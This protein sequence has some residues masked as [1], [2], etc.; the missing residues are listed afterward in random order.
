LLGVLVVAIS[1]VAF[2][3]SI[4]QAEV[5]WLVLK[6][7][8]GGLYSG[9]EIEANKEKFEASLENATVAL[10]S[11]VG[12]TK[13]A[14]TCT[15]TELVDALLNATGGLKEGAKAK[16]TG[17]KFFSG[18]TNG[19]QTEQTKC[20]PKTNGGPL[21]TVET[22]PFHALVKSHEL[23]SGEKDDTLLV[24]PD[25]AEE[26][27]ISLELGA[28]CAFGEELPTFGLLPPGL[29]RHHE[30]LRTPGSPLTRRI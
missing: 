29:R 21:G 7:P 1:L 12:I 30:S 27:V 25:N 16:F 18:G 26:R 14:I 13:I 28:S 9:A 10:L 3:A 11:E 22:L 8:T 4:A 20:Q 23:K 6:V 17:C 15:A 24:L 19:L 2:S 5:A